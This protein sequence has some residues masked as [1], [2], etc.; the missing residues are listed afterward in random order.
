[1]DYA[2]LIEKAQQAGLHQLA[3]EMR[4][5]LASGETKGSVRIPVFGGMKAGK[6]SLLARL[7]SCEQ[8][9]LPLGVLEATARNV[10]VSYSYAASR[11]VVSASGEERGVESDAEWDDLVR[12]KVSGLAATDR[13]VV[14]LPCDYLREGSLS[15]LDTPG[16]NTSD[17]LKVA[18]TWQALSGISLGIYCLRSTSILSKSDLA[19]LQA[20]SYHLDKF[21][22]L[23]TRVDE[24]GVTDVRG[25]QMAKLLEYTRERLS[26][27]GVKPVA[28]LPVSSKIQDDEASGMADLRLCL[29][30]TVSRRG[31][32]FRLAMLGTQLRH[33]V[34]SVHG[35]LCS[36]LAL[37]EQGEAL[38]A[39]EYR[40]RLVAFQERLQDIEDEGH[41]S[42]SRLETLLQKQRLSLREALLTLGNRAV[43]RLRGR[44]DAIGSGKE[45]EEQGKALLTSELDRWR[46][47]V[48]SA[49]E[50]FASSQESLLQEAS[51]GFLSALSTAVEQTMGA[52]VE[53]R[54][55][56][57]EEPVDTQALT[58]QL[59]GFES[60]RQALL[61]ELKTV[62]EQ[63]AED[64]EAVP[65]LRQN[66]AELETTLKGM[67]YEP[68]MVEQ[69]VGDT[70]GMKEALGALGSVLD[71]G[72]LLAPIPMG[73]LG[74]LTKLPAGKMLKK[75]VQY[76]NKT[77]RAKNQLLRK[78]L[79]GPKSP[80]PPT[81][82]LPGQ[83]KGKSVLDCLE[84]L[85]CEG[86]L[87]KLGEMLDGPAQ[88]VMM[89]DPTVR[90][91]YLEQVKPYQDEQHRVQC[92]IQRR[93][94]DLRYKQKR[95]EEMERGV[96][97]LTTG[98]EQLARDIEAI[99]RDIRQRND[100]RKL[101]EGRQQLLE[102]AFG[103]LMGPEAQ[104]MAPLL[105]Q[106]D[107]QFTAL[108]RQ[109]AST[110]QAR[111]A[112]SL[113]GIQDSMAEVQRSLESAEGERASRL[114]SLR[115]QCDCLKDMLANL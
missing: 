9:Y 91:Q 67:V 101:N 66:L 56:V 82:P 109:L 46:G 53:V 96:Q 60:E 16:N 95:L 11:K 93:E 27:L 83:G 75:G 15:F 21:V 111:Q 89:E 84:M 50:Q 77:I 8:A 17:E 62:R 25:E 97:S 35:T 20:A 113:K 112:E 18:E 7:L 4:A 1:M 88:T 2:T 10:E 51:A 59:Q 29:T 110:L 5:I 69:T 32:E 45:L 28:L 81:V 47:E 104:M 74:W 40:E 38:G 19:F 44:L 23:L 24:V 43:E 102:R 26:A 49:I 57:S 22:F 64:A 80:L 48:Q 106:V 52:E 54:L 72:L 41:K 71:F 107:E 37:L 33:A 58:E 12:G 55:Q 68:Q 6:S 94:A 30:D 34:E 3:E 42:A 14:E 100:S 79:S 98:Q 92:E 36:E 86:L 115:Q 114:A 87:G 103:M 99:E 63:M 105:K 78:P 108:R 65:A 13:L 39:S 31:E 73:K 61:A 70:G 90:Q 76:V 85:S